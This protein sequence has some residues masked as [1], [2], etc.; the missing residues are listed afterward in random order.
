VQDLIYHLE[1]VRGCYKYNASGLAR[2]NMIR[3]INVLKFV[4][5]YSLMR[6][7]YY[8]AIDDRRKLL[9]IGIRGTQ[10]IYDLI[11]DIASSSDGEVTFE[12]DSTHF[13]TA[14]AT[15]WFLTHE[16]GTIRTCLEKYERYRLRLV[17]HSLGGATASLLAIMLSRKSAKELGFSL[18][19]VSAVGYA[20][21]A[22]V[23]REL[24]ESCSDYVTTVVMQDDIVPRL[25]SASLTRLRN[26]ILQT[27]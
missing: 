8:I 2:N 15:R 24:A 11:I 21:P 13:G 12:A 14:E 7:E 27:D 9:I 19:I 26:E 20:T 22:C 6:P 18:D 16:I 5:N 4:N 1:L 10:T 23:S 3:E 17:G 25:S